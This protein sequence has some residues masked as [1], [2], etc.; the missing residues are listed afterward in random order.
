MTVSIL[1]SNYI[2]WKGYFDIIARSDIFVIYDEVQF[3][4][5]DWRN[6]NLIVTPQGIKWITIPVK[7]VSLNQKISETQVSN[8]NWNK[9]HKN[10]LIANYAKSPKFKEISELIFP[11][12]NSS[13]KFLSEINTSF[14]L[15]IC[16]YLNIRTEIV[17]SKILNLTGDRNERLVDACRKL[18]ATKYISGPGAKCYLNHELFEN[19][20]ISVDWMDYS[21]YTKYNQNTKQFIDQ[22]SILDLLFN[23]GKSSVDFLK[24]NKK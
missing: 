3:T 7:Q 10:T 19:N 24:Y 12:Y 16:E 17:N 23:E 14:I 11:L 8:E 1:Q 4:K 20:G 21:N 18:N 9:K 5:N 6:R 22:V 15:A 13:S 2:P